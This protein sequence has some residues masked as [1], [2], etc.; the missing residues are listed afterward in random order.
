ME[1]KAVFSERLRQW[2]TRRGLSQL[3][4]ALAAGVSQRHVS[5]LELGRTAPS[6]D[7]VLRLAAALDLPLRQQNAL[8]LAAGYAPVWRESALEEP[9][10]NAVRQALDFMLGQQEPYPA[11]VIDRRWN[12]LSANNGAR[13]LVGFLGG[14]PPPDPGAVRGINL[15]DALLA[16]DVLRPW[17]ANWE[18]V[19]LHFVRGIQADAAHDGTAETAALLNRVLSY[20]DVP[21]IARLRAAEG[22]HAPVLAMHIARDGVRLHLFTTLTTLGVAQ[23]ITVQEIRIECFFPA[24]EPTAVLLQRWAGQP[25][26]NA[27]TAGKWAATDET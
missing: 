25:I 11:F 4:L 10:L 16:P 1:K 22:R 14:G 7:M 3:A 27:A 17:I 9:E 13:R 19:A 24:N 2:R 23:D 21:S 20:P 8:L 26:A 5:F 15:A 12:V 6:R 18:S